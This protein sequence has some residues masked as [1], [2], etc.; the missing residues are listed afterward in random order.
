MLLLR[1]SAIYLASRLAAGPITLLTLAVYTRI[2]TPSEYGLYT[3][4]SGGIMLA[5]T[6]GVMWIS[7]SA[8]RLYSAA[9]DKAE[10]LSSVLI[11]YLLT[12][13][14]LAVAS[15][16]ILLLLTDESSSLLLLGLLNLAVAGWLEINLS[17]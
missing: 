11:T 3:L 8:L 2:L 13:L 14:L 16:P 6:I 12:L 4:V 1:Q 10:F 17:L 7:S 5:L 15:L 9:A